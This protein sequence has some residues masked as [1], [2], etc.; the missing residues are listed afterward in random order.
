MNQKWENHRSKGGLGT[1]TRNGP[2]REGLWAQQLTKAF[3]AV[4]RPKTLR[5][6][7]RLGGNRAEVLPPDLK[8]HEKRHTLKQPESHCYQ[9]IT[10]IPYTNLEQLNQSL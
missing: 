8:I 4:P 3:V 6:S 5:A 1:L 2:K 10:K 9:I 7:P